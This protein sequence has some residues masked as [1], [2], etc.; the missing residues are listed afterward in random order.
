[1]HARGPWATGRWRIKHPKGPNVIT[2]Y[3]KLFTAEG[4]R[5]GI[6][7]SEVLGTRGGRFGKR[8]DGKRGS[9]MISGSFSLHQGTKSRQTP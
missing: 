7:L 5:N 2:S 1:M 9:G 4:V 3:A 6:I 8:I